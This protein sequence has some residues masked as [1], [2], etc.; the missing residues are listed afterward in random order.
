MGDEVQRGIFL[1]DELDTS[2]E[3]LRSG[4]AHLQALDAANDAYPVPMHL[5]SGGMERLMKCVLAYEAIHRRG[6]APTDEDMPRTHDVERLVDLVLERVPDDKYLTRPEARDDVEFL[7]ED[8][9]L[10]RFIGVLAWFA[11]APGRYWNLNVV[12]GRATSVDS[13]EVQWQR[14]ESDLAAEAGLLE[15][16][17][18]NP[19]SVRDS[20]EYTARKLSA[21][22]ER[23]VRALCRM[24]VWA[25][26]GDDAR[27]QSGVVQD[28]L[29]LVDKE[30]GTR[31]YEGPMLT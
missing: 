30:L 1:S 19:T 11:D 2:L 23:A 18:T 16:L 13:P 20:L 4:L 9:L 22:V 15:Q 14:M 3:L 31:R 24:L 6:R 29:Y 27:A 25:D 21:L 17:K 5:L 28:F 8:D 12:R 26:L 10:R 7:K